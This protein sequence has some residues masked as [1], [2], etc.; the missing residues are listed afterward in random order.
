MVPARLTLRIH[1]DSAHGGSEWVL[2]DLVRH[3]PDGAAT[4]RC[5]YSL[6]SECPGISEPLCAPIQADR[7]IDLAHER[8]LFLGGR[9]PDGVVLG[10]V[11]FAERR[12]GRTAE[13]RDRA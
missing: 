8:K 3:T 11:V 7:Y 5:R 4:P 9:R 13:A 2:S 1:A 12:S 6:R 10:G